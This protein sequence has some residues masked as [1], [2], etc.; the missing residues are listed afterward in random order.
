MRTSTSCKPM[1]NV[2]LFLRESVWP[3]ASFE[4]ETTKESTKTKAENVFVSVLSNVLS[5]D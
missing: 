4:A 1:P 3:P 5:L 2:R